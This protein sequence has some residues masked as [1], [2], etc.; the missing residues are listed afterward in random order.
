MDQR[1]IFKMAPTTQ[2]HQARTINY[3]ELLKQ[4]PADFMAHLDRNLTEGGPKE[5]D[6]HMQLDVMTSYEGA[7]TILATER[8]VDGDT[9]GHTAATFHKKP[10]L[11]MR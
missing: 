8:N 10:E 5:E 3:E 7:P 1:P 4:N 11:L 9:I 2:S 6:A